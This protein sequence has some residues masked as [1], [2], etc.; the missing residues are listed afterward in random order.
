VSK[1]LEN[2]SLA[3]LEEISACADALS[4]AGRA[5]EERGFTPTFTMLPG[6]HISMRLD[7]TF[8]PH[9]EAAPMMPTQEQILSAVQAGMSAA[10]QVLEAVLPTILEKPA[11]EP[12][13]SE[14]NAEPERPTAPK[15]IRAP[16]PPPQPKGK[17]PARWTPEEDEALISM[18]ATARHNGI[19]NQRATTDA[20]AKLGKTAGACE[21]RSLTILKA[22]ILEQMKLLADAGQ[23]K[24]KADDPATE[25]P[26]GEPGGN[27]AARSCG[28]C[29]GAGGGRSRGDNLRSYSYST[30]LD[31]S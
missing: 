12:L 29:P 22:R 26:G 10:D 11:P 5:A 19:S 4:E 9:H 7:V 20:A 28:A 18:V 2:L 23:S 3:D 6:K 24:D 30:D 13:L 8:L 21:V 17:Q 15:P 14:A 27:A 16:S 31:S 25:K 1:F